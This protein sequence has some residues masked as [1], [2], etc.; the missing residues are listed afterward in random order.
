M[1][2]VST[3]LIQESIH[4]SVREKRTYLK[5]ISDFLGKKKKNAHR[6]RSCVNRVLSLSS[7]QQWRRGSELWLICGRKLFPIILR[8]IESEKILFMK[9]ILKTNKT[10]HLPYDE[11]L[12]NRTSG[13]QFDPR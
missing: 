5:K 13:Q 7:R 8:I 9:Y 10:D 4:S 1:G 11:K 3:C 6:C 12:K 2:D